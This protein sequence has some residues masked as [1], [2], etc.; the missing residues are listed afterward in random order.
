MGAG[1]AQPKLD[2]LDGIC[3]TNE[4]AYEQNRTPF[5]VPDRVDSIRRDGSLVRLRKLRRSK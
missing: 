2:F 5:Q 4:Y 3:S 1:T